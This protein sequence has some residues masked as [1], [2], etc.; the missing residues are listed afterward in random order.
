MPILL[1]E[2]HTFYTY[3]KWVQRNPQ[4]VLHCLW[5]FLSTA[6]KMWKWSSVLRCWSRIIIG[7]AFL[8]IPFSQPF[9]IIAASQYFIFQYQVDL[10]TRD[11]YNFISRHCKAQKRQKVVRIY[12]KEALGWC[13]VWKIIPIKRNLLRFYRGFL[14][15]L[16]KT[17]IFI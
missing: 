1:R 4:V 16:K 14:I 3:Y 15:I 17:V 5:F 8:L 6:F 7:W 12:W 11:N 9:H 13:C 10:G 2:D